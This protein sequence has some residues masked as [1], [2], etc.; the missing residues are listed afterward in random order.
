MID[1]PVVL[2]AQEVLAIHEAIKERETRKHEGCH[3]GRAQRVPGRETQAERFMRC[4][5]LDPGCLCGASGMTT[6]CDVS[7]T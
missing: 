5:V 2:R 6:E 4:R 1:V 7:T 3:P